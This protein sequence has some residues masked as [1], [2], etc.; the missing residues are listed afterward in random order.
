MKLYIWQDICWVQMK[1]IEYTMTIF[2]QCY[3]VLNN[4]IVYLTH[5]VKPLA[6]T[7]DKMKTICLFMISSKLNFVQT[8]K[9]L[10]V[11]SIS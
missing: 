9:N 4:D 6:R 3:N 2:G 11:S 10:Q 5:I 7:D 1:N 8:S